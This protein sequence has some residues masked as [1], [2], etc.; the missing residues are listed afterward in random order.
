MTVA[1]TTTIEGGASPLNQ[2]ARTHVVA[3]AV[4]GARA[5]RERREAAGRRSMVENM[6][7]ENRG[8]LVWG[9]STATVPLAL[10]RF[11]EKFSA[12]IQP[13]FSES[14]TEWVCIL[15]LARI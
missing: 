8:N 9:S 1:P 15:R 11:R 7:G 2:R 3:A 5:W 12:Q 4:A 6:G 14:R 10:R 13:K